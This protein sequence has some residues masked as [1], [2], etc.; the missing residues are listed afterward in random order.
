VSSDLKFAFRALLKSPG[1]TLVAVLTIAVAIGAN[2]ALFSIF[3]RL[4]L[5]PIDLPDADRIV[6]IWT[7][8]QERNIV[9]PIMSVPKFELFR[10]AQTSFSSIDATSFNSAV[11][12]REGADPEQLNSL[13]VTTGFIPTLGLQLAR[14][15]NFSREEDVRNGP[16]VCI[17]AYD[18]WKSRF[19]GRETLVGETIML[20]GISTTVVG[21][22]PEKLPAPISFVQLLSP[23][24]FNP[25]GLTDAQLQ[26][27]AGFLAV[28]ARLKPG[29]TFE[30]ADAEVH[31]L[32]GRYQQEHV[33]RLD[34][35]NFNELRTWI[36]EQVGPV[37]PTFVMLLTAVGFVLLIAC[38]NVSSLF[39]GRLSARHKEIA[40]RL[41]MGATRAQLVRQFLVETAVFCAIASLLGVLLA[42]WA[43]AGLERLLAAQLP[44]NTVF[45]LDPLT[46]AFTILVS[47]VA[48]AII[49]LVPAWQASRVN[50]AEVLKDTARGTSGGA[51]AS[52]FRGF[53]I[54]TEVALSVLLLV[55]S[56][57]LL[58]SFFKLQSTPAGFATRGIASAFVN[59]PLQRYATKAQQADFFYQVIDQL[60]TSPQV[61]FAAATLSMPISGFNPRGVYAVEGRPIPPTSE[62][63]IAAINFVTEDYFNLLQIPLLSG[64]LIQPT[65]LE[66]S[67][68]VVVINASFAKRLFPDKPTAV[69]QVILR[70][71]KADI[72]LE[73]VGVVGDVKSQGL[74]T[75]PP[76]TMYLPLRQ[77][78]GAGL[79][80]AVSTPGDANAMQAVLRAAVAAVDRTQA[81]SFFTTMDTALNVSLGNQ[82]ISAGLTGVFAGV[83]LLLSAVGLYSVLAYA[84]T[85]RTS[86][87]GIRMALGANKG[88]VI[89]LILSQGMRL[90]AVG[91]VIGLAGSAAGSRLL[92]SL[93]YQIE[94]LDPLV[95]GGVTLLFGIVAVFA[96]LMPS[97]RAARIDP[98]IALRAD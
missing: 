28:T 79:A 91:L 30:Q 89:N 73:I 56:G 71:Q 82:R 61:K 86:E 98:I 39:L 15:R 36:E 50:L 92:S 94:P 58:T 23:W 52:R 38:A 37:R 80:L 46:L 17:L 5:H 54:V 72:K 6:R 66:K 9:A 34:A 47:L 81:I 77:W 67:P 57:L 1:F 83:A 63:A 27:G 75:P 59:L 3:N 13:N 68:G 25:P 8:N 96:C 65:D 84:V 31:A 35:G 64:R 14:G 53:L 51:R 4:V 78:G 16:P 62:R 49:G 33:G 24:P 22:L 45:T 40:V 97:M 19:G 85:Q 12:V 74:N 93:L 2:T 48:S 10:D 29:V 11:L 20:N 87:I 95:F 21:I 55:G 41:S 26:G 43:L 90:V 32:A 69:G 60:K 44:T 42:I 18:I 7:N 76:D 88:Q 70:G